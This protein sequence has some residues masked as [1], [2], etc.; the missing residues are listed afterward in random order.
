MIFGLREDGVLMV[1]A[2]SN[3]F[4]LTSSLD[5]VQTVVASILNAIGDENFTLRAEVILHYGV[6]IVVG[7]NLGYNKQMGYRNS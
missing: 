4:L 2:L 6:G 1:V 3:L 5:G 7:L